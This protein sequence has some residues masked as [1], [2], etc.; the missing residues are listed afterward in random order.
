MRYQLLVLCLAFS[1]LS[2]AQQ[3]QRFFTSFGFG[4]AGS[5]FATSYVERPFPSQ[6]PAFYF[7]KNFIGRTFFVGLGKEMKK[8][9]SLQLRYSN[10]QFLKKLDLVDTLAGGFEFIYYGRIRHVNHLYELTLDKNVVKSST[11]N[12]KLGLG[13]YYIQ[14]I[15]GELSI[16]R[17]GVVYRER[18]MDEYNLEELGGLAEVAF[19][20]KFQPRVNIGLKSQFYYTLTAPDPESITL[21]PYVKI[22]I[23][24]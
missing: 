6:Y 7:N 10:Q 8:N 11:T 23:G 15:Q 13:V 22:M 24:K 1:I 5:F 12:L 9:Y 2:S 4:P 20:Y 19:E 21:V 3:K 14:P 16:F 17:D 18:D